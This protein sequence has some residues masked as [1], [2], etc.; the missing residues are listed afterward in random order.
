MVKSSRR[1]ARTVA[2]QALYEIDATGHSPDGVADRLVK[3]AKLSDDNADFT[4]ALV[5]EVLKHH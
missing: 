1:K 2:L 5:T 3:N 4:Q